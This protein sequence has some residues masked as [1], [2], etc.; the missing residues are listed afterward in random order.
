[1]DML[2]LLLLCCLF[3]VEQETLRDLVTSEIVGQY[4]LS[5]E[6]LLQEYAVD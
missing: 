5:L 6:H 1:M 2:E 4:C 3:T